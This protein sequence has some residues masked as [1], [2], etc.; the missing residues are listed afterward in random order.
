MAALV[1]PAEHEATKK[2]QLPNKPGVVPM[3]LLDSGLY[4]KETK[5]MIF[6]SIPKA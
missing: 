5:Q 6:D 2:Q 3:T 1:E 4:L